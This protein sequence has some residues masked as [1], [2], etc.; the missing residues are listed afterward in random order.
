MA[1]KFEIF[2]DKAGEYRVRFKYNNEVMFASEGYASK[3]SAQNAIES[4]KKN[5]PDAPVEDNT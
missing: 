5:G 3:A 2:K 4:I 1:H